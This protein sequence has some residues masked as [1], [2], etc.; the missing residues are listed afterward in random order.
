MRPLFL[1]SLPRSGS[2]LLQRILGSHDAVATS[3]EP[4][5]LLPQVYALRESGAFAEYGQVPASRAIREF[6]GRLPGGDDAYL[7]ALR[8]FAMDLYGTAAHAGALYFLD[9]TPRYHFIADDLFRI[10]PEGRFVFLWRNP[11]SVVSSIVDTWSGGR[12][13]L[14]RWHADLFEGPPNLVRALGAHRDR[15]FALRFEDLVASPGRVLPGLFAYLDLTFDPAVLEGFSSVRWQAR[16]GDPTGTARY[17]EL[18]HRAPRQVESDHPWLGA[19]AMGVVLPRLARS[20]VPGRDGGTTSRGCVRRSTRNPAGSG[21]RR[22]MPSPRC[23]RPRVERGGTRRRSSCG[24]GPV[25]EPIR[26]C[27]RGER[28]HLEPVHRVADVVRDRHDLHDRRR[29]DSI[30]GHGRRR[31]AGDERVRIDDREPVPEGL[32]RLVTREIGVGEPD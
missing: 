3:P 17:D 1:L 27:R 18:Q 30:D 10:F 2:T 29:V 7:D 31:R 9:K 25:P 13:K 15:C 28:P 6:A 8:A 24:A 19:H 26:S 14:E 32:P 23:R 4:W 12:W 20:R 11:L 5:L 16:M 21:R 22:A